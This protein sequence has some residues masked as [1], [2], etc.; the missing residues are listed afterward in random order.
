MLSSLNKGDDNDTYVLGWGW[1]GGTKHARV[2]REQ[3]AMA[4]EYA[5]NPNLMAQRIEEGNE[6]LADLA[7]YLHS[8]VEED[9]EQVPVLEV[10]NNTT[11]EE[12]TQQLTEHYR[13]DN[14]VEPEEEFIQQLVNQFRGAVASMSQQ[15]E[16][17]NEETEKAGDAD[18]N[19]G[20]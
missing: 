15:N 20:K 7:E 18:A 13:N 10:V 6:A 1:S 19:A 11:D 9:G 16:N 2:R 14:G 5:A 3:R 4:T 8:N 12:L 17:Q